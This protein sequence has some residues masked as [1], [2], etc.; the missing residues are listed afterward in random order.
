MIRADVQTND[1]SVDRGAEAPSWWRCMTRRTR[2]S[3]FVKNAIASG[4]IL[5]VILLA[6]WAIAQ[7]SVLI[8]RWLGML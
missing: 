2:V 8:L 1:R 4:G 3:F 6:G 5:L 7:T